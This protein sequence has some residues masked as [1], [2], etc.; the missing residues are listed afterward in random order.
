MSS[1]DQIKRFI[2]NAKINT[3]PDTNQEVLNELLSELD[4]TRASVHIK[5]SNIWRIIMKSRITKFATAAAVILIAVLGITFLEESTPTAIADILKAMHTVRYLHIKSF[6]LTHEEPKE[7]WFECDEFGQIENA[8]WHM[9]EWDS[10]ADGAKVV[11]WK[12]GKA[13]VWFKKK[14]G[15]LTVEDKRVIRQMLALIQA[16]DPRNI[17]GRFHIQETEGKVKIEI[18]EP[19]DKSEPIIVTATYLPQSPSPGRREVLFVDQA[20]KLVTAIEHYQLENGEYQYTSL[21][22]FL[23][24]NQPIATEMF[25]LEDEV[26]ADATWVDQTTQEVGLLQ[27]DLGNDEI[28]VEVARQFFEALI[29]EDYAKAGILLQGIPA[30]KMREM[31]GHIKFLRIVSVG[32]AAP[33]PDPKTGGVVVPSVVEIEKD[34]EIEEWKLDHLGV[35]PVYNRLDRWAVF[36]GIPLEE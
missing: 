30:P 9:P 14:G 26:P 34:G 16:Y 18:D 32:P 15:V 13:T 11:V 12:E 10:P 35:R 3:V 5:Q 28:A 4:K 22:E 6:D 17:V 19:S 21:M 31:F 8:R 2:K 20:T 24:Y 7:F 36:G 33:H 27:R 1:P 29:V 25:I 23:D